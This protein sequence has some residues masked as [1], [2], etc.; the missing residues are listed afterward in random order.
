MG[1]PP[2]SRRPLNPCSRPEIESEIIDDRWE[3]FTEKLFDGI[4]NE[5][6]PLPTHAHSAGLRRWRWRAQVGEWETKAGEN[7]THDEIGE[8]VD[9]MLAGE[10]KPTVRTRP[11]RSSGLSVSHSKLSFLWWFCMGAQG[12]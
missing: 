4:Y 3:I 10:T 5:A 8:A 11:G 7:W 12:A 2:A 9:K 1:G 6:A